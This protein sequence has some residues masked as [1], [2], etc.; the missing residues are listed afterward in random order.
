MDSAACHGRS[1]VANSSVGRRM[2]Q[3]VHYILWCQAARLLPVVV[4]LVGEMLAGHRIMRR[5]AAGG[6]NRKRTW[7]QNAACVQHSRLDLAVRS[8]RTQLWLVWSFATTR[9]PACGGNGG[10]CDE[11]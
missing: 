9:I 2:C 5:G 8:H 7:G 6:G 1:G 3:Y 10:N 11:E 4:E